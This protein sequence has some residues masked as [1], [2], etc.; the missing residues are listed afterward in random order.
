MSSSPS[1][2]ATARPLLSTDRRSSAGFLAA[3]ALGVAVAALFP[4]SDAA[5]APLVDVLF[6]AET[7][8]QPLPCRCKT[9]PLGGW[10]QRLALL[11]SLRAG[12]D[13]PLLVEVGGW[14]GGDIT[15]EVADLTARAHELMEYDA[16][17][18]GPEELRL[19]GDAAPEWLASLPL[20]CG[21]P[22]RPHD[23]PPFRIVEKHGRR[24]GVVGTAVFEPSET[25]SPAAQLDA[26]LAEMPATDVVV[27]LVAGGLGPVNLIAAS[28]EEAHVILYGDG[29]RTPSPIGRQKAIAAAP[30]S[31]GR[32]VGRLVLPEPGARAAE[33]PY[34]LI[35]VEPELRGA[36][37]MVRL[38]LRAA[39]LNEG[40]EALLEAT[41]EYS[42]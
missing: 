36:D 6:T 34:A 11:D 24:I 26:I 33:C 35:P 23:I 15:R 42:D 14:L 17:N 20:V 37:E 32:Y 29:A 10:A 7:G 30:G 1:T 41:F 25:P 18:V 3:A 12:P 27:V 40:R 2:R 16:I 39:D 22:A 28:H 13:A 31:R 38:A 19:I 21:H 5:C 9:H 8:H 4:G